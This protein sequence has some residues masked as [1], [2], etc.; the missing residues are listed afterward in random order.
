MT[1][2]QELVNWWDNEYPDW[3]KSSEGYSLIEKAKGLLE[4]E[5][6]QIAHAYE[7]GFIEEMQKV[8]KTGNEFYKSLYEQDL[9]FT[10]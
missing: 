7:M 9:Q 3:D 10:K 2:I 4:K 8:F 6:Q 5:R 1:A